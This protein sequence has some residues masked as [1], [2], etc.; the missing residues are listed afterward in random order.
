[1]RRLRQHVELSKG[2]TLFL[3]HTAGGPQAQEFLAL[4]TVPSWLLGISARARSEEVRSKLTYLQAY[5]VREVYAAY[6]RLAGLPEQG[7]R[8][9]E[10]LEELRGLDTSLGALAERQAQIESSQDKAREAWRAL[11]AQVRDVVDRL[12]AL[13]QQQEGAI[14]R[15]QRGHIYQLVQAWG[16]AKAEQDPRLRRAAAFQTVW[17]AFK[18]RF[19]LARYE[20]LPAARYREAVQFVKDSYRAL[21]G[22]DLELPEQG[23]L[24]LR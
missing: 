20:D 13:E 6:A 10:D 19:G 24:D 15:P 4:E 7:S 17:V 14:S 23:E 2:L 18:M 9:I 3:V 22:G 21:T 1:M 16:A 11:S 8:Q 5:L 12:A